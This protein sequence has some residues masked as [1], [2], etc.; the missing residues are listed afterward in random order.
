[1]CLS[2][3]ESAYFTDPWKSNQRAMTVVLISEEIVDLK[4]INQENE[5]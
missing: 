1:M 3:S 5:V 2:C 4:E